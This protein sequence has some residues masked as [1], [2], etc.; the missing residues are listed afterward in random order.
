MNIRDLTTHDMV[1]GPRVVVPGG[2]G[3]SGSYIRVMCH[4]IH[5]R[6]RCRLMRA[7]FHTA[8]DD[9]EGKSVFAA[10]A[11]ALAAQ[12]NLTDFLGSEF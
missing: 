4:V 10:D 9:S 12:R 6:G 8:L 2:G 5:L 7:I 11:A 3:C 1:A